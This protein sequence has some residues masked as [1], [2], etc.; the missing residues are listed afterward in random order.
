MIIIRMRMCVLMEKQKEVMQ[1]LLSMIELTGKEKGCQSY[2]VFRDIENLN[3]FNLFAEWN[4]R[5]DLDHHLK[6]DRFGILLGT[7][8]LLH[9]SPSIQIHTVSKSEGMEMVNSLRSKS[10]IVISI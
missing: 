4:T 7:R 1:T 8:S 10:T 9:E 3:I 6:S 5:E 2:Q